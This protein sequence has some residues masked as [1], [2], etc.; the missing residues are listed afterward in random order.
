MKITF[1]NRA[2]GRFIVALRDFVVAYSVLLTV[3]G[4]AQWW[5]DEI[6]PHFSP[7]V[8][9][10]AN[11]TVHY[12]YEFFAYSGGWTHCLEPFGTD[13]RGF[14]EEYATTNS[15]LVKCRGVAE[16]KMHLQSGPCAVVQESSNDQQSQ[17]M[18]CMTSPTT[19][20]PSED[21]GAFYID[22]VSY[23]RSVVPGPPDVITTSDS[24]PGWSIEYTYVPAPPPLWYYYLS[25]TCQCTENVRGYPMVFGWSSYYR[26]VVDLAQ[27][28]APPTIPPLPGPGG[29]RGC[30]NSKPLVTAVNSFGTLRTNWSGWIG[31]QF[32]VGS[33]PLVVT[34][35][36]RWV[37]SGNSGSHTV[38]LFNSVGTPVPG[39]SVT[40]NTAGQTP[41][42][43]AYSPLNTQLT[44]A[45]NTTYAVM[46]QEVNGGDQ[47]YDYGNT[48]I[49][50]SAEASGAFAVWA[51]PYTGAVGGSGRSYGPVNVRFCE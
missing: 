36:G 13:L 15:V 43:F 21:G 2:F 45:A 38:Q 44:L 48:Q 23:L 28:A 3:N 27:G 33:A 11:G 7:S 42:Q 20:D 30:P 9:S 25:Q 32:Q 37:V 47:W 46:S 40:V 29:G 4:H 18:N 49:T 22:T 39:G 6:G 31:F 34:E 8:P 12:Q 10:S 17:A 1:V 5:V 24:G 26:I 35:L 19:Y 51:P 41:G 50:L 16:T 14:T